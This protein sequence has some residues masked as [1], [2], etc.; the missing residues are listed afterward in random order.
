MKLK[1]ITGLKVPNLLLAVEATRDLAVLRLPGSVQAWD[2][3]AD[4]PSWKTDLPAHGRSEPHTLDIVDNRVITLCQTDVA[5]KIVAIDIADGSV[6]WTTDV[7]SPAAGGIAVAAGVVGAMVLDLSFPKP[8]RWKRHEFSLADGGRTGVF[9]ATR[10]MC[11]Q[12]IGSWFLSGGKKPTVSEPGSAESQALPAVNV[13]TAF[14]TG[15]DIYYCGKHSAASTDFLLGWWD[16][17]AG[18]LRGEVVRSTLGV[19][20][21]GGVPGDRAGRVLIRDGEEAVTLRDV[22]TGE[23]IWRVETT[24]PVSCATRIPGAFVYSQIGVPIITC[25]AE[26]D[27]SATHMK[28]PSSAQVWTSVGDKVFA[29]DL[30]TLVLLGPE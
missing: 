5:S 20:G 17:S 2:L 22:G 18:K 27:G 21:H 26:A 19:I 4:K 23:T 9:P 1:A 16:A 28:L 15:D 6:A 14:G 24:L 11:F 8:D 30:D 3:V 25:L 7:D 10:P 13:N 29:S 12:G